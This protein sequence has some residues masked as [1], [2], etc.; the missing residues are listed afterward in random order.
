MAAAENVYGRHRLQSLA[1]IMGVIFVGSLL[2]IYGVGRGFA[3]RAL[4]PSPPLMTR[5]TASRLRTCT[6]A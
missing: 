3:G 4:A 1:T 5:W 2:V 6:S